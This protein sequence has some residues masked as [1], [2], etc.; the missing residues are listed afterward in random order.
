MLVACVPGL[1]SSGQDLAPYSTVFTPL[2]MPA[3]V[4]QI[5][6]SSMWISYIA[7]VILISTAHVHGYIRAISTD[8]DPLSLRH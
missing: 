2:V 5:H 6:A 4:I 3:I 7:S 1:D 8:M